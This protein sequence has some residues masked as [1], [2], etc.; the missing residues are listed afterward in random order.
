MPSPLTSIVRRTTESVLNIL[1]CPTHE[2]YEEGLAKTG[3]N[4]F[5]IPGKHIKKWN[6]DFA[7]KPD[8]YHILP[9]Q[10]LPHW[11][12]IDL[13]L[14]QQ[15][16]G[17]YQLLAPIAKQ[18]NVP[19]ISLEHTLPVPQWTQLQLQQLQNMRGDI[20]L[21]ISD[22][23]IGEWGWEDRGDTFVIHHGVDTKTFS[24]WWENDNAEQNNRALSIVNDWIGRQWCCNFTGWQRVTQKPPALPTRVRGDT[25]GLSTATKSLSELVKEYHDSTVFFNTSVISPIPTVVLEAMSCGLPVVSTATCMIPEVIE[26]DVNGLLSNDENELRKYLEMLLED[27]TL[28]RTLGEEARSTI[29]ERYSQERFIR[30]W[31]HIFEE[32]MNG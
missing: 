2:R 7:K 3:H 16:F 23:S 8:N 5:A 15:K 6:E 13:V 26:H 17:Q 27:E 19:L 28:R 10:G 29:E 25:K 30:D 11:L 4:F 1:T 32:A 14:S 18:L 12:E 20:N 22:Y 24:P 9:N 21:F 31:N